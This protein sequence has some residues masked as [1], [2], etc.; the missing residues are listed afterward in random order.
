MANRTRRRSGCPACARQR[1]HDLRRTRAARSP[2][3]SSGPIELVLEFVSNLTRPDRDVTTTPGG[4]LDRILWRCRRGHEWETSAKQRFRHGTQCPTCL[5]GLWSSRLEFEVAELV[6]C[7]TGLTVTV[8]AEL[9]RDNRAA[10]ERVDLWIQEAD[11]LV[12]LDPSRWHGSVGGTARDARKL[13]RLAG[14]RYVRIRPRGIGRLPTGLSREE[15]QVVLG[16]DDEGEPWQ[17]SLGVVLAL[18]AYAPSIRIRIPTVEKRREARARGDLR[19]RKLRSS[20]RPRTLASEY[21]VIA[22]QFVAAVGRPKIT[23]TDLAPSGDD[24]ARWRCPAC[25]HE[26]EARVANRTLLGTGCPPCSYRRGAKLA[27]RPRPANSFADRHPKLV[28]QFLTN[29]T[30]PGTTLRDLKP[31]SVDRCRWT[32]P[33]CAR[34][35]TTTPHARN[36]RPSAGCRGCSYER[37]RRTRAR[38]KR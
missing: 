36:R 25:G 1:G 8:G 12:D 38:R 18:A 9:A 11:L 4:S 29:E 34:P 5:G 37:A 15:Q 33:C 13:E 7:T 35:W 2:A 20:C 17:W 26:W 23:A 27:A 6:R 10:E 14:E 24:R 19:W 16:C 32:C 22:D 3:L 30:N 31:N 21:P 28:G